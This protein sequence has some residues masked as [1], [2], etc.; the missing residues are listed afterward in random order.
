MRKSILITGQNELLEE[1]LIDIFLKNGY[2]IITTAAEKKEIQR[3]DVHLIPWNRRSPLSAKN[4][5]M[6]ALEENENL[7]EA[8]VLFPEVAINK[9]FHETP[10]A[11][12]E[13]AVDLQLKS[14]LFITKEIIYSMQ[15]KG[16]GTLSLIHFLPGT[17]ILP[18]LDALGSGAFTSLIKSLFTFY[19]NEA[20]SINGYFSSSTEAGNY[21]EFIFKNATDSQKSTHGKFYK[22]ADKNVFS[23]FGHSLKR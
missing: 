16:S 1:P 12:I 9:P 21:A 14:N 18:P 10:S 22:F 2:H 15:K 23:A 17:E 19:Q 3:K 6:S 8:L 11:E 20:I 13:W 7:D 5:I 4:V